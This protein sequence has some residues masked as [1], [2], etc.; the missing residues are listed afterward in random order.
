MSGLDRPPAPNRR[1][2][3]KGTRVRLKANGAGKHEQ[4]LLLETRL[5]D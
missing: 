2:F 4:R 3:R 1:A 5:A